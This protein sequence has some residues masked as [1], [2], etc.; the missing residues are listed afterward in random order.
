MKVPPKRKGNRAGNRP[1]P[2]YTRASMKALPKRKG[3]R[4][5]SHTL[6]SLMQ[7]ASMK[8]PPTWKGIPVLAVIGE[9]AVASMKV[10]TKL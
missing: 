7:H 2:R 1:S 9:I 3:N 10:P 4:P 8:A 5:P 6:L